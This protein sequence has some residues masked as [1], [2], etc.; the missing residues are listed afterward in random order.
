MFPPAPPGAVTIRAGTS[1]PGDRC[2]R[3]CRPARPPPG[4][5]RRRRA[6]AHRGQRD[7][8]LR[9]QVRV[10][11]HQRDVGR[12]ARA[13]ARRV[14]VLQQGGGDVLADDAA[15]RQQRQAVGQQP[16][17][18]RPRPARPRPAPA[19]PARGPRR[20]RV[21]VRPPH[22]G[23]LRR[24][25]DPPGHREPGVAP[26][27]PGEG[28]GPVPEHR[29][30][31]GL[32]QLQRGR[33]VEDRLHPGA[34]RQHGRAGQRREVGRDVPALPRARGAPRRARRWRTPRRPAVAASAAVAATVVAPSR[35]RPTATPR[36]RTDSLHRARRRRTPGPAR[37][38]SDP[39]AGPVEHGDGRRHGAV[40]PARSPPA[41][42]P[43]RGC[44]ARGA[45][46]RAA[47]SRAR[48]R[49]RRRGAL[50]EPRA[51][52]RD[53]SRAASWTTWRPRCCPTSTPAP[54][55]PTPTGDDTPKM[56]HYV[57]KAKIAES[58]VLGNHRGGA[59]R[60]DLPG[61]PL[62]RSRGHRCART[63]R[64]STSRCRPAATSS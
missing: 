44:A 40:G 54:R 27:E 57:L 48:R 36:S 5:R 31:R 46:A 14:E 33:D 19:G 35:P 17:V 59:V 45:R 63:A 12:E 8:D 52:R 2:R 25:V 20:R 50:R 34:H 32:Q 15:L 6:G 29:H 30:R 4:R 21:A 3:G 58:A 38:P 24:V 26:V 60:R 7:G 62:A 41:R 49:A 28:V 16:V 55:A 47:C 1:A 64:R 22:R 51:R 42:R 53:G 56:F 18:Q 10:G 61:D 23:H 9:G 37:P 39:P 43:P 11:P 13:A